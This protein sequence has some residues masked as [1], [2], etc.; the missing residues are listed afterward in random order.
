MTSV[1]ASPLVIVLTGPSGVGKDVLINRLE[2][3]GVPV[4]IGRAHV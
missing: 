4:E 1:T 2:E 3:L